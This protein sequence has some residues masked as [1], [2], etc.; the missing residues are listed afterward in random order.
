MGVRRLTT[1]ALLA[2]VVLTALTIGTQ[3]GAGAGVQTT[4]IST[5]QGEVAPGTLN[6]GWWD[7]KGMH[8]VGLENYL[9]GFD[10][11]LANRNHRDFFTFDVSLANGMCATAATVQLPIGTGSGDYAEVATWANFVLHDVS[12]DPATLNTTAGPDLD[13]FRD[14]GT[15]TIY[16]NRYLPTHAPYGDLTAFPVSLNAAGLAALNDEIQSP[17]PGYF[18]LGGMIQGEAPDVWLFGFTPVVHHDVVKAPVRL[19]I[20]VGSC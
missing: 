19:V 13:V 18:S 17:H 10:R 9:A 20:T 15:G 1:A 4:V 5:R 7:E 3:P 14:L 8:V 12:T 11:E 2:L 6:M 16:G